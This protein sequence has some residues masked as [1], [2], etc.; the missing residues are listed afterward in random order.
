MGNG[1]Q[2]PHITPTYIF[3]WGAENYGNIFL[4]IC[5]KYAKCQLE[6]PPWVS[7]LSLHLS[8]HFMLYQSLMYQQENFQKLPM[9]P[10][11]NYAT[12]CQKLKYFSKTGEK[13]KQHVILTLFWAQLKFL[14]HGSPHDY[15][16]HIEYHHIVLLI[17]NR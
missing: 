3:T 1:A 8:S 17:C 6:Y 7:T 12:L 11:I 4:Y 9:Y 5:P 16:S 2:I 15:W 13:V 10:V 14:T